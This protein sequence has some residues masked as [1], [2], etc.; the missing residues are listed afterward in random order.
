MSKQELKRQLRIAEKEAFDYKC[1]IDVMKTQLFRQEAMIDI[2]AK[3][4]IEYTNVQAKSKEVVEEF[5]YP[6]WF[7]N[8]LGIVCKF[9]SLNKGENVKANKGIFILQRHT[10]TATWTQVE[11][12]K[13]TQTYYEVLDPNGPS[14]PYIIDTL[15]LEKD[16]PKDWIKTGRSFEL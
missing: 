15:Y 12:P 1:T 6:M 8:T 5:T 16:I 4:L 14:C 9:V 7:Q 11:E 13:A 10:D 3:K 2:Q